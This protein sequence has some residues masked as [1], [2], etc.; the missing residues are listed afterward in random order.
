MSYVLRDYQQEALDSIRACQKTEEAALLTVLPTGAGKTVV[1]SALIER[2]LAEG[3]RVLVFAHLEGLVHQLAGSFRALTGAEVVVEQGQTTGLQDS[4]GAAVCVTTIQTFN[5]RPSVFA[6]FRATLIDETHR[7]LADDYGAALALLGAGRGGDMPLFG[8]TATDYRGDG[9]SMLE[10]FDEV[11][12]SK[13]LLWAWENGWLVRVRSERLHEVDPVDRYVEAYA[14][15]TERGGA[16]GI[17]TIIMAANVQRGREISAELRDRG[18]EA[19]MVDSLAG[20]DGDTQE[21][22]AGFKAGDFDVLVAYQQVCEGF[23]APRAKA[24]II[25]RNTESPVTYVQALGRVLRPVPELM[26]DD[27]WERFNAA[28]TTSE[29]RLEILEGQVAYVDDL[30]GTSERHNLMTVGRAFGL[31]SEFD[32]AGEDVFSTLEELQTLAEGYDISTVAI[33]S[34]EHLE[35]LM[36]KSEL[37][38]QA[39]EPNVGVP[40][41]AGLVYTKQMDRWT[42]I[43][44]THVTASYQDGRQT[45]KTEVR[46]S[47]LLTIEQDE[48]GAWQATLR[49]PESYHH[50]AYYRNQYHV[51]PYLGW[52]RK[53]RPDMARKM[54]K[55]QRQLYIH[56]SPAGPERITRNQTKAG[57]FHWAEKWVE[58]EMPE[59]YH[60]KRKDARWRSDP[61]S[62]PQQRQLAKMVKGGI[63]M[64]P[65]LD[66]G[67]AST[68]IDNYRQG[69]IRP[70]KPGRTRRKKLQGL[71]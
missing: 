53:N 66:K 41:S 71:V 59:A 25:E 65:R 33:D 55:S 30:I 15:G 39:V 1:Q 37:W 47:Q 36:L 13:T 24:L 19:Y 9:R 64:P 21:L 63:A 43:L 54:G 12:F 3:R 2:L 31:K 44:P 11:A 56:I 58:R 32:F 42:C 6:G 27:D 29:E 48:M 28:G 62:A 67:R 20:G 68:M 61:V 60:L 50:W 45:N 35:E 7:A 49:R 17:P 23:D 57:C 22:L 70:W 34:M 14:P 5:S 52:D 46:V 26:T 38:E 40:N 16:A 4:P 69:L 10:L 8:F 51:R 18:F